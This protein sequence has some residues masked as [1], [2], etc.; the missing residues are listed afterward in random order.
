M[1]LK[2]LGDTSVWLDLAKDY[3]QQP[4]IS[5]LEDLV[6]AGAIDLLVPQVVLDEFAR[7]KHRVALDAARSLKSHFNLVR[8]AISRFGEGT[9]KGAALR[10][11]DEVD[12]AAII[13]GEAVNASMSRIE[14]LLASVPTL[15]TTDAIKARV[16]D[17]AIA[18]RAPY[19]RSK[20]SAGDAVIIEIYADH[21]AADRQGDTRL[22][23]VTHNV[24]DFSEA[25][26]DQRKPHADLLPLFDGTISTYSVDLIDLINQIDEDLLANHDLEFNGFFQ[27]RRLSEI[28]EAEHL[29]FRQVWYNRH[30]NLRTEI[31]RGEHHVVSKEN[32]STKPYLP[33]QT[34]DTVWGQAL[35]AAKRTEDEVGIENLGPWDDFEW[36]MLNGK[37]SALRWVMGDEWDMLD[38]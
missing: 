14:K 18:N 8:D 7:N 26:G 36:G 4:V 24:R 5:A 2:L 10:T 28:L 6:E 31:E 34:L 23:F 17:R 13:K 38:T 27:P 16:T 29:L 37:L 20:N 11:L 30:W 15:P 19:H 1:T 32:Y 12:H 9:E 35:A 22:A 3:R 33:D 25:N 21:V